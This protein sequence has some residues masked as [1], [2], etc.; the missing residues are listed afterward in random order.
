MRYIKL[1]EEMEDFDIQWEENP[2]DDHIIN[3]GRI[4][5]IDKSKE[6]QVLFYGIETEDY[7]I[8]PGEDTGGESAGIE[9]NDDGLEVG[10]NLKIRYQYMDDYEGVME[11]SGELF[12]INNDGEE[13]PIN[14]YSEGGNGGVFL[15]IK[16]KDNKST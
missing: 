2:V 15:E 14:V 6:Y 11:L 3:L 16:P 10:S 13:Y 9:Y 12:L 8:T 1:F 4:T 7:M 5:R